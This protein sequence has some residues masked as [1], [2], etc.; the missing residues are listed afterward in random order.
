MPKIKL[1]EFVIE[2]RSKKWIFRS[3]HKNLDS[4]Q[5]NYEAIRNKAV[6]IKQNGVVIQQKGKENAKENIT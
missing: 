2:V 4:A 1:K 6:R 5:A 3:D